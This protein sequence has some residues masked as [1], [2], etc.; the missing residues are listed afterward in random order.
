LKEFTSSE[1]ADLF[2]ALGDESRLRILDLLCCQELCACHILDEFSFTQPT[3][4]HHMRI[5]T[6]AGLVQGRKEGKWTYY[7]LNGETLERLGSY[8]RALSDER[9]REHGA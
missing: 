5:L 6:D 8:F 4:S 3:L 1:C 2:K 7:S 9:N